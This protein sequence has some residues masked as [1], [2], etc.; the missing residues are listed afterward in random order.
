MYSKILTGLDFCERPKD[1]CVVLVA[2]NP[3]MKMF[4]C[5]CECDEMVSGEI[6]IAVLLQ[7]TV[8]TQDITTAAVAV[9]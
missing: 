4:L 6:E 2:K 3:S 7:F 9:V 5:E 1:R 8:F